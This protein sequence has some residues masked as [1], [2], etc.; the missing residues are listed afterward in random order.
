MFPE[1]AFAAGK[2]TEHGL[3]QAQRLPKLKFPQ[4]FT[5]YFATCFPHG[6]TKGIERLQ[7][8]G[9]KVDGEWGLHKCDLNS[10]CITS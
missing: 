3:V 2:W 9:S 10:I 5:D 7:F 1:P 4:R 8:V 6:S